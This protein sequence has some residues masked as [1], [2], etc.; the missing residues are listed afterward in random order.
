M[1]INSEKIKALRKSKSLTQADISSAVGVTQGMI[2]QIEQGTRNVSMDTMEQLAKI[3]GC[4]V[5]ELSK[6]GEPTPFVRLVRNCKGLTEKQ[7]NAVNHVVCALI[8]KKW[9]DK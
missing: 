1:K 4:S 3:L 2:S 7:I 8:A 5:D 6:D 9:L